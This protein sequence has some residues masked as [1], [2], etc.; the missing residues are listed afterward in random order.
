MSASVTITCDCGASTTAPVD[1]A[2]AWNKAP[3]A[4]CP[5]AV[6]SSV[7]DDV[8]AERA[9]QDVKWGVQNHPDGTGPGTYPLRTLYDSAPA[10]W[11]ARRATSSTDTAANAGTVTWR[12]ILLEEVFEALAEDDPARLRTELVQV[13]AV[14]QQ[15]AEAIDRRRAHRG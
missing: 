13:A 4:T 11:L 5:L 9:R 1:E 2:L 12:H 15:W 3:D 8:A 10:E 7:A 6:R 14:A